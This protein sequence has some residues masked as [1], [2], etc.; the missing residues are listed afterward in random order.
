MKFS[1][2]LGRSSTL[3]RSSSKS[4]PQDPQLHAGSLSADVEKQR[5]AHSGSQ[6]A[7]SSLAAP[8]PYT[9]V[10]TEIHTHGA[11]HTSRSFPAAGSS[12]ATET[13]ATPDRLRDIAYLRAPMR[14]ES[15][16]NA[17]DML[18]AYDTVVIMDDSASMLKEHRWEQACQALSELAQVAA[19]YD[20]DGIDIHFLNTLNLA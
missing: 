15:K 3:G 14:K 9:S 17:L 12:R 8:P 11:H 4:K 7:S 18:S 20:R 13:F 16:E 10:A 5:P 2:P 1:L 19:T 6:W